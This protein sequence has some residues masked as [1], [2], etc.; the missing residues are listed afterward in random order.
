MSDRPVARPSVMV[1]VYDRA[2]GAAFARWPV[3]A[4]E[5]LATGAYTPDPPSE[6]SVPTPVDVSPVVEPAADASSAPKSR[7]ARP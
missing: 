6:A 2:T 1:T 5:L 7:K 4:Q 3:D